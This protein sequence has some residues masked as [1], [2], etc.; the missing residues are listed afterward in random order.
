MDWTRIKH[1][2]TIKLIQWNCIQYSLNTVYF[3]VLSSFLPQR[4]SSVVD[5]DDGDAR[6]SLST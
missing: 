5:A 4:W 1:T 3:W 6:N 2:V